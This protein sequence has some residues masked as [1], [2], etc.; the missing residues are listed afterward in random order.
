MRRLWRACSFVVFLGVAGTVAAVPA[1]A[2]LSVIG[3]QFQIEWLFPNT[4]TVNTGPLTVTA[5]HAVELANFGNT[6]SIDIEDATITLTDTRTGGPFTAAAFNGLYLVDQSESPFADATITSSA[7][8]WGSAV[9][10]FTS[11]SVY[12]NF[13]GLS[14]VSGNQVVVGLESAPEPSTLA[15]LGAGL[16]LFALHRRKRKPA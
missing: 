7:G 15:L 1:R 2:S 12:V 8:D 5:T 9:V 3:D 14:V 4:S 16:A 11:N 13:Q 6:W 10:T